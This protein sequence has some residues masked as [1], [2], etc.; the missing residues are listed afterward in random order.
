[1]RTRAKLF[2][3]IWTAGSLGELAILPYALE[4]QQRAAQDLAVSL[5]VLIILSFVQGSVLVAA[6]TAMGLFFATRVGFQFPV[7][8]AL[9]WVNPAT[10]GW[11][12]FVLSPL[13]IGALTAIVIGLADWLFGQAGAA[14]QLAQM[15]AIPVSKRFLAAI[16]GGISE[17]IIMRLFLMSMLVWVLARLSGSTA[18]L[19]NGG[20][21]WTA[22][23]IVALGFGL[24]HLPVTATVV[25]LT[26][27]V[28]ARGVVLNG[29]AG[30]V[31]GWLYWKRGLAA[32]MV[33]HFAADIVLLI[34]WPATFG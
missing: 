32:A 16:Y 21:V 19:A 22:N 27:L 33:A 6:A 5:P 13:A 15:N 3:A 31:F 29:I 9:L 14:V 4:V 1:M 10:I 20:L 23:G 28:V 12:H 30:L 26:A 34:T 7:F 25:E 18:P 11:A 2:L 17:E 8:Q 24:G